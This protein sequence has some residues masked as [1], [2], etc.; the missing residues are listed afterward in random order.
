MLLLMP[1]NALLLLLL[2]RGWCV[3]CCDALLLLRGG[4]GKGLLP[5]LP[6]GGAVAG[7]AAAEGVVLLT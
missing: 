3:Y 2:D 5:K 1:G 7:V 4:A 6:T